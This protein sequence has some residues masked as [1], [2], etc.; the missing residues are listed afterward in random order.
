MIVQN[1][2]EKRLVDLGRDRHSGEQMIVN[3]PKY[4]CPICAETTV[5]KIDASRFETNERE[6]FDKE[7]GD[8]IPYETVHCDFHCKVCIS[9]VRVVCR[10]HEFAMSSYNYYP[11]QVFE[12]QWPQLSH[13]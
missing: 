11:L 12:V 8:A 1:S 4:E 7:S 13:G 9:P 3:L 2:P 10:M 5:F 6:I